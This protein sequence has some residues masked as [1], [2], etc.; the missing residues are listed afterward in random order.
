MK[1]ILQLV[2]AP[3]SQSCSAVSPYERWL[4]FGIWFLMVS[5]TLTAVIFQVHQMCRA[6]LDQSPSHKT[7]PCRS[8]SL[9]GR[10]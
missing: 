8:Q 4:A 5:V 9:V 7:P 1:N 3:K 10:K 2:N 6:E